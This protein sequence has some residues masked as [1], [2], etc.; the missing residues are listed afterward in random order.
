MKKQCCVSIIS[1]PKKFWT[2]L[3]PLK[4]N[5]Y[6]VG[7]LIGTALILSAN[8]VLA[9]WR[10]NLAFAPEYYY[11]Q[12]NA[13]GVKLLDESGLRYGLDLSGKQIQTESWLWAA[14]LKIYYGRVDYNGQTMGG[15][16]V[17]STTDYLGGFGEMRFGY[18]WSLAKH[19][20]VELM[21][22][23]GLE[24]WERS[25]NGSGGYDENWLPIYFKA[26]LE[27]TP[28]PKGLIGTL[29]FKLPVYTVQT[30]DLSRQGGPTF[31]LYPG[32]MPSLY[33]ELGY[34]FSKHLSAEAF[35][36]S[37]WFAQS[38][39]RYINLGGGYEAGFY[40]PESKTYRVG[41]KVGWTF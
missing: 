19:Q 1:K 35:F 40:Q 3:Q 4:C 6:S 14:E 5:I 24:D 10:W 32:I 7:A 9:Q 16:P 8:S 2:K 37:Y 39:T 33:A 12:E 18:R 34:Q 22:G 26:G 28:D 30:A 20:R 17:K 29:G 11:W 15:T 41:V 13:N 23:F 21:G 25:L 36:D 31:N 27:L 38:P